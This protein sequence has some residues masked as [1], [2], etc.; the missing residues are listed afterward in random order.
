MKTVK[1]SKLLEKDAFDF[2]SDCLI[3]KPIPD[4]FA[5][6]IVTDPLSL[7][8]RPV[9]EWQAFGKYFNQFNGTCSDIILSEQC[10]MF[11]NMINSDLEFIGC[12]GT[13]CGSADNDHDTVQGMH[14]FYFGCKF[15]TAAKE[16]PYAGKSS[17]Y[18]TCPSEMSVE[19][20]EDKLL[21]T[22][23][24]NL[25]VICIAILLALLMFCYTCLKTMPA[26]KKK[27]KGFYN[28]KSKYESTEKE[29]KPLKTITIR[30]E[31]GSF[32]MISFCF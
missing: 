19:N 21:Q 15:N 12:G 26:L 31:N 25:S 1:Y 3:K 11:R 10:Q 16:I 23:Y 8:H 22:Q 30:K 9:P 18:G 27:V 5:A 4:D 13:H 17:F 29:T 14:W 2:T 20:F 32:S 7:G 24:I 28:R 6:I